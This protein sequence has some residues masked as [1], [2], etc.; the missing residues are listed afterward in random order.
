M[1]YGVHSVHN[2]L[3][4]QLGKEIKK[5]QQ[6]CVTLSKEVCFEVED[7]KAGETQTP[8]PYFFNQ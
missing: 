6:Q 2:F 4:F 8:A 1:E 7:G 5:N 3:G